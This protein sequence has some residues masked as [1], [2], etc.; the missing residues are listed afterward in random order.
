MIVYYLIGIE[1]V[2]VSSLDTIRLCCNFVKIMIFSCAVKRTSDKLNPIIDKLIEKPNDT[3][4]KEN[5][6]R[7]WCVTLLGRLQV[8]FQEPLYLVDNSEVINITYRRISFAW[9]TITNR[10][11]YLIF[12]FFKS[13]CILNQLKNLFFNLLI[14]KRKN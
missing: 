7:R 5:F 10:F 13:K 11:S 14:T 2:T 8:V 4:K 1:P 9:R 3:K 6:L 12:V